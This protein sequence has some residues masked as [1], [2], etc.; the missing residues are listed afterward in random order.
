[1][2]WRSTVGKALKTM[3]VQINAPPK[4]QASLSTS[5]TA[6]TRNNKDRN[7]LLHKRDTIEPDVIAKLVEI[8]QGRLRAISTGEL[9]N[10]DD[11]TPNDRFRCF[12]VDTALVWTVIALRLKNPN[13]AEHFV[14]EIVR[15]ALERSS[16]DTTR[17]DKLTSLLSAARVI[18]D[19]HIESERNGD[20]WFPIHM[21][22][23]FSFVYDINPTEPEQRRALGYRAV[24]LGPHIWPLYA[25]VCNVLGDEVS[26][27][28]IDEAD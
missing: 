11:L 7:P 17:D 20:R 8:F 12:V 14:S 19:R 10:F 6:T 22:S 2:G 18:V 24:G 1:M 3:V 9:Y 26:R 5:S 4:S 23:S 27:K 28:W 13:D 21:I 16:I 25:D 15:Q